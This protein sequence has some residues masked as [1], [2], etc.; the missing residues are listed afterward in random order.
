MISF[1]LVAIGQIFRSMVLHQEKLTGSAPTRVHLETAE[2]IQ[3]MN[4]FPSPL[5][6]QEPEMTVFQDGPESGQENAHKL[7]VK[8]A[9]FL[10]SEDEEKSS[11]AADERHESSEKLRGVKY[12]IDGW[13]HGRFQNGAW[14]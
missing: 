11:I 9:D 3:I 5:L 2:S 13:E 7:G 12:M 8:E 6:Q 10:E 14:R 4:C 1:L